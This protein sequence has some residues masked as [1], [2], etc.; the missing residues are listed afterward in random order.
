[1]GIFSKL[2]GENESIKYAKE[3][4]KTYLEFAKYAEEDDFSK[5][6]MKFDEMMYIEKKWSNLTNVPMSSCKPLAS[7]ICKIFINEMTKEEVLGEIEFMKKFIINPAN[8]DSNEKDLFD[9]YM[10]EIMR[11]AKRLP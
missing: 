6:N 2:R 8:V 11:I 10:A 5:V 1:M 3:F 7:L 4:K 9:W